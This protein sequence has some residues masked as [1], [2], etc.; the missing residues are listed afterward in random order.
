MKMEFKYHDCKLVRIM[1]NLTKHTQ[2]RSGWHSD[3]TLK[4]LIINVL[5]GNEVFQE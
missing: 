5:T 2:Q 4:N 3:V 1:Q